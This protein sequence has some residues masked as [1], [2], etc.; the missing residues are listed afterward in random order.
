MKLTV[1]DLS[2]EPS[3]QPIKIEAV[4]QRYG[5]T[6]IGDFCVK[7][8]SGSWSEVPA[9]LFYQPNPNTELGHTNLFAIFFHM[10]QMYIAGGDNSFD[11]P[12][13]GIIADDGE[14]IYSRYRHDYRTSTD[15]SV[16]IDGGRDYLKFSGNPDRLCSLVL[17]KDKLVVVPESI[18]FDMNLKDSLL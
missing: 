3:E 5:G 1:M 7:L 14:V 4:E 13:S 10:D 16:S 18:K 11:E 17:D 8:K 15:G 6:Y 2:K 9:A 12:I